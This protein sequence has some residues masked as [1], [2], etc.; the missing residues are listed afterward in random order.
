MPLTYSFHLTNGQ[1]ISGFTAWSSTRDPS[2]VF[3]LLEQLYGDFDE[4]ARKR[5]VCDL[6]ALQ[7]CCYHTAEN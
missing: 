1:D 7:L 6:L 3:A 5:K 4:I 2:Q